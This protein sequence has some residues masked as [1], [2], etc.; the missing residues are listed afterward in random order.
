MK[1]DISN[2][3]DYNIAA[4][5][6]GPGIPELDTL[7]VLITGEIRRVCGMPETSGPLVREEPTDIVALRRCV[8]WLRDKVPEH[9]Y[10]RYA[11]VHWLSHARRALFHLG[12][13]PEHWLYRFVHLLAEM[14]YDPD[15]PSIIDRIS[16][17]LDEFTEKGSRIGGKE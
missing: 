8:Y 17:H 3:D 14:V 1:L 15:Y 13:V 5:L 4:A 12:C 2:I 9:R 16:Q 11:V 7:K 10:L 6:T